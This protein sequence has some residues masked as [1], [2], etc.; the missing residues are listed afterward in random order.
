MDKPATDKPEE[1][2]KQD[3]KESV[4]LVTTPEVKKEP[5]EEQSSETPEVQKMETEPVS[6]FLLFK[7]VF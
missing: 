3:V 5:E 1:V 2:K 7:I 6:G 4:S